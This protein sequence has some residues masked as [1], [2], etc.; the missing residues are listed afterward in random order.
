ME[1]GAFPRDTFKHYD[2]KT[3]K[4]Y[5]TVVVGVLEYFRSLEW[6]RR[7]E[8]ERRRGRGERMTKRRKEGGD[9]WMERYE[10]KQGGRGRCVCV[11][12]CVCVSE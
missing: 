10:M 3:P 4:V 1:K 5:A 8:G 2:T 11:C 7:G 6:T 9:G 12:V